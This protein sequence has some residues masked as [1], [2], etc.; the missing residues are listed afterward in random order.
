MRLI[1]WNCFRGDALA[2]AADLDDL[3]P[4]VVVLQ[5]CSRP[6]AADAETF[7]WSG[8]NPRHGMAVVTRAPYVLR[9]PAVPAAATDS[10]FAVQ[11]DGPLRFTLLAVWAHPK[12]SYVGSVWAGLNA[13]A[14]L[15]RAGDAVVAGDFNSNPRW[16]AGKRRNHTA[17]ERRLREEF[18]LVSAWHAAADRASGGV[19]EPEPDTYHHQWHPDRG[20]HIDYCFI[21]E[22]WV[23]RVTA[24]VPDEPARTRRSDHRPLIIDV[25]PGSLA[26]KD[27]IADPERS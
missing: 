2:R 25:E 18:G 14:A 21:P 9:A 10:M 12:P 26:A 11:V 15:L 7:A 19:P 20:F 4:D 17:L 16:D 8:D 22:S 24:H 3:A 5:E 27:T 6:A 13:H 1:T 23:P